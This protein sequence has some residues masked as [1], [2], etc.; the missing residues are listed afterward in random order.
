MPIAA[1]VSVGKNVACKLAEKAPSNDGPST[2]PAITSP[3]T[4]GWPSLAA[5]YP[6]IRQTISTIA[7]AR[8]TAATRWLKS[9]R[10]LVAVNFSPA[11]P[12]PE[13]VVSTGLAVGT[14]DGAGVATWRGITVT[15]CSR[16]S[17]AVAV[18]RAVPP[19]THLTSPNTPPVLVE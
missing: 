11:G 1:S 18:I 2:S 19:L 3:M 6:K 14:F 5:M 9:L 7:S 16:M 10:C 17:F 4:R 8:N 13:G 15:F 12:R